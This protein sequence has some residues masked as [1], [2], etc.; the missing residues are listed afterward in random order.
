MISASIPRFRVIWQQTQFSIHTEINYWH[1]ETWKVLPPSLRRAKGAQHSFLP[2]TGL[3]PQAS[4][5]QKVPNTTS[6]HQ[7]VLPPSLRRAK[8]AQYNYFPLLCPSLFSDSY[9]T[10]FS[11]PNSI[12]SRNT[13]PNRQRGSRKYLGSP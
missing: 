3:T 9:T 8:G 13:L 4:V 5:E 11:P 10:N 1:N 6:S 7:R 2:P 12:P